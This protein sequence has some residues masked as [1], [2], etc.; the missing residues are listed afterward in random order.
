MTPVPCHGLMFGL[1]SSYFSVTGFADAL[2][3]DTQRNS[4]KANI[5]LDLEFGEALAR[6]T[7]DAENRA[8]RLPITFPCWVVQVSGG[9]IA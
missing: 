1:E 2:L 6:K 9:G 8:L 4:E 5:P 7:I 3:Q